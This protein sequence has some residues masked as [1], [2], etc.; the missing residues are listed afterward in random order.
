M[1]D[2]QKLPSFDDFV[3]VRRSDL[4]DLVQKVRVLWNS[5]QPDVSPQ[6][7]RVDQ[8]LMSDAGVAGARIQSKRL[9]SAVRQM[10][11]RVE[12]NQANAFLLV[13]PGL[14]EDVVQQIFN[15]V[16]DGVISSTEQDIGKEAWDA[17]RTRLGRHGVAVQGA[18]VPLSKVQHEG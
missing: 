7:L 15:Q 11:F 17:V 1:Q 9:S 4:D 13:P 2:S 5:V 16:L 14:N 18:A 6:H 3:V 8:G 12:G 10:P